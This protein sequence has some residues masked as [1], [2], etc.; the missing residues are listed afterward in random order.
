M[1][2]SRGSSIPRIKPGSPELQ[3]DFL[4]AELQGSPK[5][6]LYYT[7]Q[8]RIQS[9]RN[10]QFVTFKKDKSDRNV[11]NEKEKRFRLRVL[12]YISLMFVKSFR[13]LYL[14]I[15]RIKTTVHN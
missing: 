4:P 5:I 12:F 11:K 15:V 10:I 8:N 9:N 1:P 13:I 6:S 7:M 14:C 3:A 2:S